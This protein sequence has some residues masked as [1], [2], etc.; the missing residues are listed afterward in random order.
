M[1]SAMTVAVV[2]A[3]ARGVVIGSVRS[4][5]KANRTVGVGVIGIS[6]YILICMKK[7]DLVYVCGIYIDLGIYDRRW[8]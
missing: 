2:S 8:S 7:L 4:T 3:V 5:L 6:T 1:F